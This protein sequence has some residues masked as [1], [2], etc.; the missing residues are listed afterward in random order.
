MAMFCSFSLNHSSKKL[1]H[2]TNLPRGIVHRPNLL[3][4]W[5]YYTSTNLLPTRRSLEF[6]YWGKL[7]WRP[8][9]FSCRVA[10]YVLYSSE[11]WG[12]TW[13]NFLECPRTLGRKTHL[14]DW[15]DFGYEI[16]WLKKKILPQKMEIRRKSPLTVAASQIITVIASIITGGDAASAAGNK[17]HS[18][19]TEREKFVGIQMIFKQ[20]SANFQLIF[21]CIPCLMSLRIFLHLPHVFINHSH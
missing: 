9:T 21:R 2:T 14:T 8:K 18:K 17:C 6:R 7:F 15:K 11:R 12:Q 10:F 3:S 13:H 5:F 19:C 16:R 4:K 1:C 20:H